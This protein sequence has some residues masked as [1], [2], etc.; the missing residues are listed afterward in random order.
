[1]RAEMR[2][3]EKRAG[4][5]I[6]QVVMHLVHHQRQTGISR[7][8]LLLVGAGEDQNSGR[9]QQAEER[10]SHLFRLSLR[11]RSTGLRAAITSSRRVTRVECGAVF[12]FSGSATHSSAMSRIAAM[13]RSNSSLLSVSVGSIIIAP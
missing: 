12:T 4:R 11:Q 6:G 5:R 7:R 10:S 8:G 1:M 9:R 2:L 3:E 13:N